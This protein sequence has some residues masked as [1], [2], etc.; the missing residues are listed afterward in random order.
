[1]TTDPRIDAYIA[2]QADFA[3]P[4]LEHVRAVVH[5]ACPQVEETIKWSM[6]TFVYGGGILC[7]MAAFKQ[8]ASFG[9]WKHALVVGEGEPRDGMGSYGKLTSLKE[10]PPKKTLIAHIRKAMQLNLEKAPPTRKAS[11]PKP[12]PEVP[13]DL[14]AALKKNAKARKHYEAFPPG[15]QREY[16]EWITD[17]KR[18][19]TRASRLA[20]A[21]EWIAEGKR[22]NWK[23]E[24]CR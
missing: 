14:A 19:E 10:L 24:N 2:R 4:I 21:V 1:M 22:R 6:P 18:E 20:Q 7:G 3:R 15:A 8:H 11:A 16:V 17:A 23:Y 9:Y 5:E 12:P 13:T